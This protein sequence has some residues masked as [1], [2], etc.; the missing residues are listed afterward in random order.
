M[1]TVAHRHN[2][3]DGSKSLALGFMCARVRVRA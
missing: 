3:H 2:R 1:A